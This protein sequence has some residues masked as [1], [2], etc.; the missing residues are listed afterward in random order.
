MYV[1]VR[2]VSLL[3]NV[4]SGKQFNRRTKMYLLE[5]N[6]NST[7]RSSCR[8][9]AEAFLKYLLPCGKQG[10]FSTAISD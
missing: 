8:R 1:S 7:D 9:A 4:F 6:E 10:R 2:L 3:H 5:D